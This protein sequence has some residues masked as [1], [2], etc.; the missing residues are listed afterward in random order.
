MAAAW[1]FSCQNRTGSQV[2]ICVPSVE[3][4]TFLESA[5]Y[6]RSPL[7]LWRSQHWGNLLPPLGLATVLDL[8]PSR[9]FFCGHSHGLWRVTID[10]GD[11]MDSRRF[12]DLTRTVA[13]GRSRRT[14]LQSFVGVLV[15][16]V[17]GGL[18][19]RS[20][21][22]DACTVDGDCDIEWVCV[23]GVC[24]PE[25]CGSQFDGCDQQDCCWG[26]YCV[27]DGLYCVQST[28]QTDDDCDLVYAD[29][30]HPCILGVCVGRLSEIGESCEIDA[31]CDDAFCSGGICTAPLAE[32]DPCTSNTQCG[33]GRCVDGT[34]LHQCIR[35]GH[36]CDVDID[37]CDGLICADRLC[38][39]P[40]D[41]P[42]VVEETPE[43]G[44][45]GG[46]TPIDGTGSAPEPTPI[47]VVGE[48]PLA[49]PNTGSGSKVAPDH[50]LQFGAG[51]AV[52][53][54]ALAIA[55]RMRSHPE[56]SEG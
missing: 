46:A 47:P 28:C 35:H 20:V 51:V 45:S 14:L 56:G 49:L 24:A 29:P 11:S 38:T 50:D 21:R 52:A 7:A 5:C 44:G 18:T 30:E 39:T 43:N 23:G 26:F 8:M 40:N 34:C 32:G 1:L 19:T 54:A 22:A 12:D 37:C 25:T 3:T 36:V 16:L 48:Q 55:K 17:G 33:S 53:A 31:H 9:C 41:Q 13:A 27:S 10:K 15:G 6:F 42:T 2:A 4:R